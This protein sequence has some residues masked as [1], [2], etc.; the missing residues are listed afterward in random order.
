MKWFDSNKHVILILL[1]I[2]ALFFLYKQLGIE[3]ERY[4]SNMRTIDILTEKNKIISR[5][6]E[7]EILQEV[8]ILEGIAENTRRL[9][10]DGSRPEYSIKSYLLKYVYSFLD[11]SGVTDFESISIG[12]LIVENDDPMWGKIVVTV[13]GIQGMDTYDDVIKFISRLET[14]DKLVYINQLD[15][16][17]IEE[18][19]PPYKLSLTMEFPI[20]LG[21]E[22]HD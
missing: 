16:E 22:D 6:N 13:N 19:D 10:V 7:D 5:I 21:G 9:L 18:G 15:I 17:Y 2:L 3:F 14:I 20:V 12:R 8:T 1:L 11:R 4:R